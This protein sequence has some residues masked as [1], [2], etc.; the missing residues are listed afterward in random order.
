M[1]FDNCNSFF[2]FKKK[3]EKDLIAGQVYKYEY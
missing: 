2:Y 3:I 1:H